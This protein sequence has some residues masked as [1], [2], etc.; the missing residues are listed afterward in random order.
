MWNPI[1]SYLWEQINQEVA[2]PLLMEQLTSIFSRSSFYRKKFAGSLLNR[3]LGLPDFKHLPFTEK[4]ELV[5]DEQTNPPF[6]SYLATNPESIVRVHRTSGTSALPLILALSQTDIEQ[7]VECGARCF[8]AAGLRPNDMVVH[9]LNYCMWSG[10]LTDHQSL[11]RTGAAV[12]PYGVGNSSNLIRTILSLRPTAIHCTPSYLTRLQTILK[13]E[14][15]MEPRA[16]GLSLGLFGGEGGLQDSD[17]RRH[18]EEVWGFRAMDANY[19]AADILSMFGAECHAR[20]GLH[21]MGQGVIHPE[22]KNLKDDTILNWEKGAR[23]EFVFTSLRKECQPLVRYRSH[24]VVEILDI[25][26][27]LCGRKS[28]RFKIVGRLEDMLVVRGINVFV[29]SIAACI[30][31]NLDRLTG[32]FRIR[33]NRKDPIEQCIVAVEAKTNKDYEGLE[34]NLEEQFR[35]LIYFKP[36]VEILAEG[37]LPR[38]EGKTHRLE[39]IL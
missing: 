18:I 17:F 24:D 28:P 39:R 34:Q 13:Q 26:P 1:E 9:C 35:Q 12:I 19:G 23:G 4:H 30:N 15:S 14:F 21:F 27:C 7:T 10:G 11:E 31:R 36:V 37:S 38:T 29:S 2:K 20:D 16:L 33:V 25:N 22:L 6:G 5:D 8:W 32:E 3:A